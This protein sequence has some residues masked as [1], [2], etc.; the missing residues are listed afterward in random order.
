VQRVKE[1]L[2]LVTARIL[3]IYLRLIG[4]TLRV[5]FVSHA[6]ATSNDPSF[7][8]SGSTRRIYTFWI[9]DHLN[10]LALA[11]ASPR[12]AELATTF[13]FFVDDSFGGHVMQACLRTLNLKPLMI[14]DTDQAQR[15][16]LL[17][18]IAAA[19]PHA[20]YL[21]VDGRGPYFKVRTG[22]VNFAALVRAKLICTGIV[23]SRS[24]ALPRRL[25]S[26]SIPLPGAAIAVAIGEDTEI[27]SKDAASQAQYFEKELLAIRL[28]GSRVLEADT[29]FPKA[30]GA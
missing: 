18:A 22:V 21:A 8:T 23:A 28:L 30:V 20:I 7:I 27:A 10:L 1:R 13:S 29:Q 3:L 12:F 2:A 15:L 11:Y 14:S 6:G 17:R 5:L 4:P 19:P 16:K 9:A 26:V 25:G 24:I